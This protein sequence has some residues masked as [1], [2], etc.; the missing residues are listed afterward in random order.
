MINNHGTG[1]PSNFTW[2]IFSTQQAKNLAYFGYKKDKLRD[3]KS[4]EKKKVD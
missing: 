2:P 1:P 4:F 3:S